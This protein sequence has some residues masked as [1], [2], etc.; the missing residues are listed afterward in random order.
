MQTNLVSRKK[1]VKYYNRFLASLG[2]TPQLIEKGEMMRHRRIISL[3]Y[4]VIIRH[5][6]RSEE[7]DNTT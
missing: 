2:M 5:S 3:P 1:D 4:P 6:E 7:S